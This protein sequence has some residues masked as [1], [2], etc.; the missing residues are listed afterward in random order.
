MPQVTNAKVDNR[1][2]A[3]DGVN[4]YEPVVD[5]TVANT[6]AETPPTWLTWIDFNVILP[7]TCAKLID[8]VSGMVKSGRVLAL[9][10]PSGA[11]KTTLL[12]GLSGRA[13]YAR[14]TGSVRFAGRKMSSADLTYVPQFDEINDVLTVMDHILFVGHL[15]CIDESDMTTRAHRRL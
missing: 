6:G 14:V 4:S 3:V 12:N 11:G 9:M 15:T 7:K 8:N 13:K 2:E 10:G 1:I 5:S